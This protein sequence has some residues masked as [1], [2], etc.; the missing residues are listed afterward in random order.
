MLLCSRWV[1]RQLIDEHK[2]KHV[3][4]FRAFLTCYHADSEEFL[5]CT[6]M[7]DKTWI[8]YYEPYP[9]NHGFTEFHSI[10]YS[11]YQIKF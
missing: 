3:Q 9:L 7:R 8:H 4:S 1:P 5:A 10:G 11:E 2:L 6:V